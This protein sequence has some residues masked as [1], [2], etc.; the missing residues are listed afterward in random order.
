MGIVM[1]MAKL[2]VL[3]TSE[4]ALR[5]ITLEVFGPAKEIWQPPDFASR[6]RSPR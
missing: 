5:E 1:Y 4:G 2:D 6:V 3:V